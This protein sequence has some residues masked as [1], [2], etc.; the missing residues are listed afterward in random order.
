MGNRALVLADRSMPKPDAEAQ[1]S[2]VVVQAEIDDKVSAGYVSQAVDL[3]AYKLT[4]IPGS[5]W[6]VRTLRRL[7]L[8]NNLLEVC[9]CAL[10]HACRR[11]PALHA[12]DSRLGH[13]FVFATP[14]TP[15]SV[16]PS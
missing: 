15:L 11:A 14:R 8:Q 10:P 5:V 16:L 2:A 3:H 7:L 6:A 12:P 4:E 13:W 1:K 9:P